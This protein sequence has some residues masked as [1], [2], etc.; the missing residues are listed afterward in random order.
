MVVSIHQKPYDKQ[1]K[2]AMSFSIL[3]IEFDFLKI[4]H[5]QGT[6]IVTI[7]FYFK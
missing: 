1:L 3:A 5:L 6:L 4:G 2:L 7:V